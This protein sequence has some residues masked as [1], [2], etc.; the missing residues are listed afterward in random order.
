MLATGAPLSDPRAIDIEPDGDLVV[1]DG[2]S[3]GGSVIH[4][5]RETGAKSILASGG[6][7][8]VPAGLGVVG[9][10]GVDQSGGGNGDPDGPAAPPPPTPIPVRR[11]AR[12]A[13][14]AGCPGLPALR[15]RPAAAVS[16]SRSPTAAPSRSRPA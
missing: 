2:Q 13:G 5:D 6:A 9:G 14:R 8:R 11:A 4:V 3:A 10:A 7:F 15:A 1:A 12:H 16:P